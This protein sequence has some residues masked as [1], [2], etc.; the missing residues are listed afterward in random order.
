MKN[1]CKALPITLALSTY[2]V[3]HHRFLR[4]P[5]LSPICSLSH[6]QTPTYA[7]TLQLLGVTKLCRILHPGAVWPHYWVLGF[8]FLDL[9]RETCIAIRDTGELLVCFLREVNK[10]MGTPMP[11]R[12][13]K[14]HLTLSFHSKVLAAHMKQL[15]SK[16]SKNYLYWK[17]SPE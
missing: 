16:F 14:L 8:L 6:T 11:M 7:M 10:F 1:K 15:H 5:K 4:Q 13:R 2:D 3:Q 17:Q 9:L 12:G